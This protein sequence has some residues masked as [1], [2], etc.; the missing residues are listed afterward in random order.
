MFYNLKVSYVGEKENGEATKKKIEILCQ[1]ENFTD[2]ESLYYKLVDIL[3]FDKIEQ[4]DYDI[5]KTKFSYHHLVVNDVM[6]I[7]DKVTMGLA[8]M[9]F[10]NEGDAVYKIK[11]KYI[12]QNE[13]EKASTTEWLVPAESASQAIKECFND[14]SNKGYDTS[15]YKVIDQKM[16]NVEYIYLRPS[17]YE[18]L[19]KKNQ[20]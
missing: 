1:C 4:S 2:T 10:E 18:S 20:K 17:T 11:L 14:M 15:S 16:L 7:E 13:G 12:P 9:Y 6:D 5:V 3:K 8:Q 19:L